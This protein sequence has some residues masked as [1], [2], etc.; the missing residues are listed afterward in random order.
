MPFFAS[1]ENIDGLAALFMALLYLPFVAVLALIARIL[2]RSSRTRRASKRWAIFCM[3]ACAPLVLVNVYLVIKGGGF[4]LLQVS[5]FLAPMFVAVAVFL[6]DLCC[7]P[8]DRKLDQTQSK[9]RASDTG[10]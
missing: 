2:A 3:L 4:G 6:F 5:F 7:L 9:N 10:P 1:F 8:K